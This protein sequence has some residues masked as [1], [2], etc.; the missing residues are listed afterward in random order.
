MEKVNNA[1]IKDYTTYRLDGKIR[2]I[3]FPFNE[4]ELKEI[5]ED[6]DGQKYKVIGNGSNLILSESY[7]GVLINLKYFDRL[8][9][10]DNIVKV[11]AGY[12]LPKFALECANRGLSGLEFASG[13]P[14]TI[15][16]AIYMNAGAYGKEISDILKS[17]TILDDEFNIRVLSKEDLSAS[18]RD[19]I[20]KHKKYVCLEGEFQLEYGDK[21]KILEEI[22]S[23]IETRKS[24]QPL[25][26]PSAGSVFKNGD[27]YSAGRVI[28]KAGLKGT[29]VGDAEVSLKHANFIVNK[30]NASA[31]DIIKLIDIIKKKIKDECDIDL[32]LEQEIVK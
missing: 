16:G 27:G 14:G 20:F 9:F 26:Y 30:G 5:L 17:V 6:L 10:N 8:E 13:I 12:S 7:D 23:I 15:G 29:K 25:E 18:Y 3:L 19:S 22:K 1:L 24:K 21:D 32:I 28:E 2:E 11:G 4:I 31:S